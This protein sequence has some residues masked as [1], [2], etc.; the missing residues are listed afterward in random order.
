MVYEPDWE[1]LVIDSP[2]WEVTR[3]L[4]NLNCDTMKRNG[5]IGFEMPAAFKDTGLQ[6][7][8]VAFG[9]LSFTDFEVADQVVHLRSFAQMGTDAKVISQEE[10]TQWLDHLED[11][12]KRDRFFCAI[13][14]FTV[15]G[16]K[17]E[18]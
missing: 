13:T 11:A 12:A 1:T 6:E 2:Y 15:A 8:A 9:G 7:V 10:A 14:G 17:P 3:K 16:T 4:T 18:S 5:R